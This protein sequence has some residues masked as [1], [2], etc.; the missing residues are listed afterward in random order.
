VGGAD[1]GR[2]AH[3]PL[4]GEEAE[5]GLSVAKSFAF[6]E[7]WGLPGQPQSACRSSSWVL[8]SSSC[9]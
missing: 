8:G 2:N 3:R 1:A 4:G 9:R 5:L 6:A 7:R